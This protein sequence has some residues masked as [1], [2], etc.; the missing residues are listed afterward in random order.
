MGSYI[1][2]KKINVV[3][4]RLL[5]FTVYAITQQVGFASHTEITPGRGWLVPVGKVGTEV[6]AV[7]LD[8]SLLR[9]KGTWIA[10]LGEWTDDNPLEEQWELSKRLVST[11][12]ANGLQEG[13][14]EASESSSI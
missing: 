3:F 8:K 1:Q 10:K 5:E 4:Q 11:D 13:R 6:D 2:K 7:D 9:C 12:K 14:K